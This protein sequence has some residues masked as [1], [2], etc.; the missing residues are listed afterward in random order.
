M[1]PTTLHK[2]FKFHMI[3]FTGYGVIA[4]QPSNSHLPQI[5]P[6]TLREKLCFGLKND[7]AP[8]RMVWTSSTSMQSLGMIELRTLAVA[9]IIWCLYVYLPAGLPQSGKCWYC[10]YSQVKNQHF[11]SAGATHCSDSPEIWHYQGAC[12][13]AWPH[14][15]LRQSVHGGGNVDPKISIF[16][17]FG[18]ESPHRG[19]PFYRFLKILR[20][21]IC[22]TIL[23]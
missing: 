1:R 6:C 2:C 16:P 23:H 15:I 9:A 8:F 20:A 10:F 12:V 7:F 4:E 21:F 3:H 14:E 17:L 19:K 13:S 11:H 22:P 5:L 18:K